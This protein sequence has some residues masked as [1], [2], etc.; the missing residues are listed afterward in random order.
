MAC[1]YSCFLQNKD[2]FS[3]LVTFLIYFLLGFKKEVPH[4]RKITQ[5][6]TIQAANYSMFCEICWVGYTVGLGYFYLHLP[7][8]TAL[9]SF[10]IP[11]GLSKAGDSS[12]N[13]E[14]VN[15]LLLSRRMAAQ[16]CVLITGLQLP[17]SLSMIK[18]SRRRRKNYNPSTIQKPIRI[19]HTLP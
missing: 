14:N 3:N 17:N 7:L 18:C 8:S 2:H 10:H 4:Q 6:W 19:W 12:K 16:A 9:L 15:S 13:V 5:L 1:V 11:P